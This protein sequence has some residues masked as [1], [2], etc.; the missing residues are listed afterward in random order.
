MKNIIFIAPPAAGKGTFSDM[1]AKKY[2]YEHISTGD[3]LRDA[4]NKND[5]LGQEIS[6]LM[7]S[8]KLVPDKIVLELLENYIKK[9][10][11][12]KRFILDGV[13]RNVSQIA[14]VLNIFKEMGIDDYVVIFLDVDYE[15]AMKRTLGRLTCPKCK[16]GYN[17]FSEEFKPKEDNLCDDCQ[18]ELVRRNDDTA[19][20]FK[21]RYDTYMSETAP[22]VDYFKKIGK[23]EL[24]TVLDKAVD[25]LPQI[26][27]IIK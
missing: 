9:I 15:K 13:P 10:D 14:P 6:Q 1:L 23:L 21:I 3:L 7:S 19:E 8:G 4:K 27:R 24:I 2:G 5:A 16:R 11:P 26:E 22:I 18:T 25:N 17:E 12:S 20:T